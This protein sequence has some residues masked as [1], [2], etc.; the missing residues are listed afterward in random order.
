MKNFTKLTAMILVVIIAFSMAACSLTPDWSY[1][2]GDEELPIG[3]YIYS[4]YSAYNQAQSLAQKTD[5]YDSEAGTYDGEKSFLKVEITDDDGKKATADEWIVEQAEKS[6][7]TLLAINS[8]LERLGATFDQAQLDQYDSSAKEYWDY[9]PYYSM[10]GEQYINPYSNIFEPYGVSY[11]SFK[12]AFVTANK[13]SVLFDK[14]Y[15]KD[16]EKAVSDEELTSFFTDNYTS[17]RFMTVDLF[18]T[19][20]VTGEDGETKSESKSLSDE[21]IKKYETAFA[22]YVE[23]VNA[24][25]SI[26]DVIKTYMADYS[27]ENDPSRASVEVMDDS[28]IGADLV[29]EIKALGDNKASYKII[30]EGDSKVLYLFYKE[31]ITNKV[32]DY[33]GDESN[34]ETVLQKMKSDEFSD[35]IDSIAQKIEVE[36]SSAVDKYKPDMFED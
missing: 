9:G 21:E 13:Q 4:M 7:K 30:G 22:G 27:I 26:D 10:Y 2:S 31:A 12:Y 33:I 11:E 17:Y 3:V 34:R 25:G 28:N 14:L 1:K 24:G 35:Y 29:K 32:K 36:R 19:E 18:T 15:A 8:E 6:V 20:D 23:T 16:G 5:G